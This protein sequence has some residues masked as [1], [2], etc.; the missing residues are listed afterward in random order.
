[1][2]Q[3]FLANYIERHRHPANQILH[4]VG[5]PVTFVVPV[6]CLIERQWWW[7]AA[8]FV[9]GYV[10]QF[11]GHAVEGNDAGELILLKRLL[12]KPAVEFGPR[13]RHFKQSSRSD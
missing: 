1:M 4:L 11:I 2:L 12:G 10:L 5:L 9:G 6:V 8:A 3:R 7:A 13:S